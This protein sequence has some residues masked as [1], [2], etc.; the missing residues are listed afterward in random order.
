MITVVTHSNK[1]QL[2]FGIESWKRHVLS[3]NPTNFFMP[4]KFGGDSASCLI[5]QTLQSLQKFSNWIRSLTWRELEPLHPNFPDFILSDPF[6]F[7]YP[8]LRSSSINLVFA[9]LPHSQFRLSQ[10]PDLVE[11]LL[12]SLICCA[13]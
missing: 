9:S 4:Q 5:A 1:R 10:F 7:R 12:G 2:G 8:F 6:I 11:A 13:F 3:V